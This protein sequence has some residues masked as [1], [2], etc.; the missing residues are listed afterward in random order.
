MQIFVNTLTG[1]IMVD[2][3]YDLQLLAKKRPL[4][5]TITLDW[6]FPKTL[7][8]NTIT[9]DWD[10][11]DTIDDLKAQIQDKNGIPPQRLTF[12]DTELEGNMSLDQ[13]FMK[14]IDVV[15]A[16]DETAEAA[17]VVAAEMRR[18]AADA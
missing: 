10:H 5:G 14:V 2:W 6:I 4:T 1:A 9:V 3:I 17:V 16:A 13:F 8:G 7:T 15:N 11:P 18:R 12:A